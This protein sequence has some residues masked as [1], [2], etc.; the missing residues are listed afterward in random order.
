MSAGIHGELHRMGVAEL[1]RALRERKVSALE[2]ARHHLDRIDRHKDIAAFVAVDE[3]LTLAQAR[4]A[5]ARIAAGQAAE[6]D[7][8][9]IAHKDIFVT[10]DLQTTAGSRMLAGYRSPFDATV[11]RRL[12]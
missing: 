2:A 7:G 3:E 10:A 11:V 5:D 12:A 8:V 6:L 4:A 9:P 1:A